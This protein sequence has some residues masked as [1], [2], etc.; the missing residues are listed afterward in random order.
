MHFQIKAIV[1]GLLSDRD[2]LRPDGSFPS[3]EEFDHHGDVAAGVCG[4]RLGA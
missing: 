1:E 2:G 4:T 3:Q